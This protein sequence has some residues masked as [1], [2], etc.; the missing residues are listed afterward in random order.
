MKFQKQGWVVDDP[1]EPNLLLGN[2]I[3]HPYGTN[4]DYEES[5]IR[6]SAMNKFQVGFD[7]GARQAVQ[8]QGDK[9]IQDCPTT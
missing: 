1:L 6:F 4:I 5:V 3:L 2:D 9:Q 7:V 8:T